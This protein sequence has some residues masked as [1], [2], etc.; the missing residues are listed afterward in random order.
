V[1]LDEP[2]GGVDPV[3]RRQFWRLID[4]LSAGGVTVLVTTHYLDEA[5]HCHRVAIM[6]AGRLA[7]LGS[8]DELKEIFGDR[9]IF[10]VQAL[11]PVQAMRVL[12]TMPEIEKTSVFGTAVHAVVRPGEQLGAAAL[13]GRLD[14]AG[15]QVTGIGPVL[16]SLEDVFLEVA[17]TAAAG[18]TPASA[19]S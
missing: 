2:T 4:D 12:D 7:A 8:V 14:A 9:A 19:R 17:E 1:F 15:V 5:E 10:E 6:H 3:S 11:N 13:R 18:P 16:P